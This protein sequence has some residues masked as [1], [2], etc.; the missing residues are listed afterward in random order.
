MRQ[1]RRVTHI[2]AARVRKLKGGEPSSIGGRALEGIVSMGARVKVGDGGLIAHSSGV[3]HGCREESSI[4]LNFA[5][6]VAIKW[7]NMC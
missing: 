5:L 3:L 7:D 2:I 1:S 4:W 6:R